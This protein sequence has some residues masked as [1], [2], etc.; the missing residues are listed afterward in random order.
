MLFFTN[1][2]AGEDFLSASINRGLDNEKSVNVKVKLQDFMN[3]FTFI[4]EILSEVK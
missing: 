1:P 3:D 2:E 4:M